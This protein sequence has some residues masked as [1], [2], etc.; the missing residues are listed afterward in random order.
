ML[1]LPGL[2][3]PQGPGGAYLFTLTRAGDAARLASLTARIESLARVHG[4]RTLVDVPANSLRPL[5]GAF[6]DTALTIQHWTSEEAQHAFLADSA[7]AA[8]SIERA[9]LGEAVVL[10]RK[11]IETV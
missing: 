7:Y 9:A 6:F 11:G 2:A 5:E 3:A 10:A 4:G 1:N 8:L